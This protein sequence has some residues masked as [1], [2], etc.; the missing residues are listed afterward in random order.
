MVFIETQIYTKAIDELLD[1]DEQKDLQTLIQS[2]PQKG[3]VIRG[4]GGIRKLRFAQSQ[5]QKGKRGG[6][7][8]IYLLDLPEVT[9]LLLAYAKGRK[10]DLSPDEKKTLKK[11]A[12][13]LKEV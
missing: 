1:D 7:R 13:S 12:D 4:T 2:Q 6:V 11:L 8:I 3:E 5:K 9:Y 10:D